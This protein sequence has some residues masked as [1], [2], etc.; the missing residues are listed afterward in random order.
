ME[1]SGPEPVAAMHAHTIT[2]PPPCSAEELLC[3]GSRALWEFHC[4]KSYFW[5]LFLAADVCQNA[6]NPET[7]ANFYFSGLFNPFRSF[8]ILPG[9]TSVSLNMKCPHNET[10]TEQIVNNI[11]TFIIKLYIYT[12][13]P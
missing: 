2:P 8:F 10:Q 11:F 13:D 9:P 6:K 12:I 5:T 1:I 7:A 4:W 3:F